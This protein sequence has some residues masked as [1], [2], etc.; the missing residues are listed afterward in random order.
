[1]QTA[2][3][4]DNHRIVTVL[5]SIFNACFCNLYGV[6]LSH[7]ETFGICFFRNHVKLLDCRRSV[8]IPCNQKH[9]FVLLFEIGC[10]FAA[11]R[12]LARA[13]QTAHHIDCGLFVAY[14]E[15]LMRAA[16]ERAKFVVDDFDDLLRRRQGF[17]NIL[18]QRLFAHFCR[19]IL[20]DVVVYVRFEQS[21]ANFTH[22]LLY[23]KF[24]QLAFVAEF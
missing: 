8:Y 10:K 19:K 24:R 2:C 17:K 5:Q 18:A 15:F 14:G 22:S 16:H 4:V 23:L 3:G 21:N 13:L 20:Y 6:Y 7:I 11:H 1:M 9:F 12:G